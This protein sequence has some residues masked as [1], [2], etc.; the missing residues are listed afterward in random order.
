MFQSAP[1]VDIDLP[2]ATTVQCYVLDLGR[3]DSTKDDP[4]SAQ[5]KH[6]GH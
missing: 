1:G 4:D 5:N 3:E 6:Q 2:D